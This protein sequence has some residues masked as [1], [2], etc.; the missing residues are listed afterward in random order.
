MTTR[1]YI[2]R[3]ACRQAVENLFRQVVFAGFTRHPRLPN[4]NNVLR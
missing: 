3:V 4:A 2:I 1:D